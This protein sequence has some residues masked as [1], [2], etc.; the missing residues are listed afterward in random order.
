MTKLNFQ[1]RAAGAH[2]EA[3]NPLGAVD[4]C[5][6]HRERQPVKRYTKAE[7]EAFVRERT[8]VL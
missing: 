2:G 5:W 4:G 1:R 3:A 6:S 8:E 7:I